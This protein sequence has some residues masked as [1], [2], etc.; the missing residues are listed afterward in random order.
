MTPT[1]AAQATRPAPRGRRPGTLA[2]PAA[3]RD[4]SARHAERLASK[5]RRVQEDAIDD[6]ARARKDKA[7]IPTGLDIIF[8]Q[9]TPVVVANDRMVL[10]CAKQAKGTTSEEGPGG[11]VDPQS[12][13]AELTQGKDTK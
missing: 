13:L 2:T 8:T 9:L 10:E 5:A 4:R 7:P 6:I 11:L 1:E 12:I 3:L